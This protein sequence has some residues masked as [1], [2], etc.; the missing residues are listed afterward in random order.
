MIR[1]QVVSAGWVVAFILGVLVG[2]QACRRESGPPPPLA[3]EA[4]PAEFD[5]TFKDAKPKA[6]ELA[7]QITASLSKSNYP[8]AYAQV[9]ALCAEPEANKEQK[10]LAARALLTITDLLQTAQSRGD[11]KAAEALTIQKRYR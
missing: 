6:K 10:A 11:E 9:Q 3:A 2:G 5:K 1:N 8:A 4:I 7:T